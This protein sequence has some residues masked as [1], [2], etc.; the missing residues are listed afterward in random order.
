MKKVLVLVIL[1]LLSLSCE[2][3]ATDFKG[4]GELTIGQ[5]FDSLPASKSF[6]KVMNDE[7]FADRFKLSKA[8]GLVGKLNVSTANGKINQVKFSNTEETNMAEV[9]KITA[10]LVEEKE[11]DSKLEKLVKD[12]N[13]VLKMYKTPDEKIFFSVMQHKD[14]QLK[15]GQS[16]YEFCYFNEEAVQISHNLILKEISISNNK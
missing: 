14:Q 1:S 9:E 8:L 6:R 5:N 3:K 7:F 10:G 4:V 2:K 16:V 13:I 15:N 12:Q 11:V